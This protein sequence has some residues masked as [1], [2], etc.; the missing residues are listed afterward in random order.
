MVAH[1]RPLSF[2]A[3]IAKS[4]IV[5]ETSPTPSSVQ[6]VGTDRPVAALNKPMVKYHSD[7]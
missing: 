7:G 6:P 4:A 3:V 2:H 1:Q 5:T